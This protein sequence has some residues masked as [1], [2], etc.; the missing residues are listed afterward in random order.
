MTA[1]AEVSGGTFLRGGCRGRA[2]I[3]PKQ[4]LDSHQQYGGKPEPSRIRIRAPTPGCAGRGACVPVPTRYRRGRNRIGL[5]VAQCCEVWPPRK[6]VMHRNRSLERL[7]R[8]FELYRCGIKGPD[9]D[10][11]SCDRACE[12]REARRGGRARDEA[13]SGGGPQLL[14]LVGSAAGIERDPLRIPVRA[15]LHDTAIDLVV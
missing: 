12:L 6:Y 3:S 1:C 10:S 5:R 2:P 13:H 14:K 8:R 15:K 11:S 9:K 4:R 7:R